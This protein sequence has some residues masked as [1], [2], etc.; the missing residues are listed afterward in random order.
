MKSSLIM[1]SISAHIAD[2]NYGTPGCRTRRLEADAEIEK[3]LGR[4]RD[5][6]NEYGTE[7]FSNG[8]EHGQGYSFNDETA[9]RICAEFEEVL[10]SL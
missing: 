1:N 6:F 9:T 3:A 2:E 8:E 7:A 10:R 5:L 4:L